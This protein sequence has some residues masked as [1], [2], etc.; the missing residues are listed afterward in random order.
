M[1]HKSVVFL[2]L[3]PAPGVVAGHLVEIQL[4]YQ[5]L[6]QFV[7]IIMF[8]AF[9]ESPAAYHIHPLVLFD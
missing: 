5:L 1:R 3:F 4:I 9:Y 2:P 7:I 8:G 6:T